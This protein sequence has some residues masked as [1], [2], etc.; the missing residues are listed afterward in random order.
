MGGGCAI[1]VWI[2]RWFKV[3]TAFLDKF[4]AASWL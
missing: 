3:E 1:Y 2:C 4:D